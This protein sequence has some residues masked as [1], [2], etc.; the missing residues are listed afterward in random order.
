M[1]FDIPVPHAAAAALI[2]IARLPSSYTKDTR[3]RRILGFVLNRKIS[4]LAAFPV[5]DLCSIARHVLDPLF[6]PNTTPFRSFF[7]FRFF[8]TFA[9]AASKN[10]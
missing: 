3:T 5:K 7:V 6:E 8:S 1:S 10:Q 2:S 4:V 9:L